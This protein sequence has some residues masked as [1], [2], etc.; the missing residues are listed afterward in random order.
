M[1][2][3]NILCAMFIVLLSVLAGTASQRL[4]RPGRLEFNRLKRD[5]NANTLDRMVKRD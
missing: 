2:I 5:A 3:F 4:P 1:K